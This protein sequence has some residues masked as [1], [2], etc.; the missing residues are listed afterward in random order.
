[1]QEEKKTKAYFVNAETNEHFYMGEGSLE[2]TQDGEKWTAKAKMEVTRTQ[3]VLN[4]L[5]FV[6]INGGEKEKQEAARVLDTLYSNLDS[7]EIVERDDKKGVTYHWNVKAGIREANADKAVK[8]V[9]VLPI[10][11]GAVKHVFQVSQTPGP[12]DVKRDGGP[13]RMSPYMAQ[14]RIPE[15][16]GGGT[17]T[18]YK[19]PQIELS[20]AEAKFERQVI[21]RLLRDNSILDRKHPAYLLGNDLKET[22]SGPEAWTREVEVW[23]NGSGLEVAHL[24]YARLNISWADLYKA[25]ADKPAAEISGKERKTIR[26]LLDGMK[27]KLGETVWQREVERDG[28]KFVQR[29]RFESPLIMQA[30]LSELTPE[31]AAAADAGGEVPEEKERLL[32]LF[33]PA[34]THD[35]DKISHTFPADYDRRLSKAIGKGRKVKTTHDRLFIYLN[36]VRCG[37]VKDTKANLETL[38]QIMGLERIRAKQGLPQAKKEIAAG[39]DIARKI[40]L[41]KEYTTTPGAKGQEQYQITFNPEFIAA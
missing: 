8:E 15:K 21:L 5:H 13:L 6:V 9:L 34:Y 30:G 27:A 17:K 40:R 18:T 37:G 29:L 19:K 32:L 1:M 25:Y 38:I 22:E 7:L 11:Q 39:L 28:Q 4:L 33:H 24:P 35:I 36:H 16:E 41:I 23:D 10:M 26:A 20:P 14:T 12:G 3:A 2:V 31:E